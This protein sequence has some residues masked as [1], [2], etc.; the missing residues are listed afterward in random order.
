MHL[1]IMYLASYFTGPIGATRSP[2]ERL[3][4]QISLDLPGSRRRRD[5]TL[6]RAAQLVR[7]L[8]RHT[9]HRDEDLVEW[10]QVAVACERHICARDGVGR[11][12]DVFPEARSLDTVGNWVT[13]H[14]KR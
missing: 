8:P 14:A 6:T 1:I 5:A 9:V 12:H 13:R 7:H 11:G 4:T 10:D 3:P 2:L